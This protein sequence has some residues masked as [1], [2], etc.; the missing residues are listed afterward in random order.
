MYNKS[1]EDGS[2]SL[3]LTSIQ[4][5]NP[6]IYCNTCLI[7]LSSFAYCK[8]KLSVRATQENFHLLDC[9]GIF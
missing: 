8:Y 6:L 5:N 2:V 1:F 7:L 4:D 3:Y 9:K